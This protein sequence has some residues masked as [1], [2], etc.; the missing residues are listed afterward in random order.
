MGYFSIDKKSKSM[1]DADVGAR[2][3]ERTS[4]DVDAY[5]LILRSK[6][7]LLSFEEP[8]RFIFCALRLARGLG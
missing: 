3:A 1:V 4:D 6:A 2:S 7:Q 8:V 5:D